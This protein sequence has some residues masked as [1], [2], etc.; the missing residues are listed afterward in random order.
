[1]AVL[2]FTNIVPLGFAFKH[3]VSH[4]CPF[5]RPQLLKDEIISYSLDILTFLKQHKIICCMILRF[6]QTKTTIYLYT[7]LT[8]NMLRKQFYIQM[9][10]KTLHTLYQFKLLLNCTYIVGSCNLR[11]LN[12]LVNIWGNLSMRNTTISI[13]I[14]DPHC[15]LS[16]E[17]KFALQMVILWIVIHSTELVIN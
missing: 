16:G 13:D 14:T 5:F 2:S 17:H 7:S 1:M 4:F 9:L 6:Q 12:P 11:M 3:R 10:S 15:L 8:W